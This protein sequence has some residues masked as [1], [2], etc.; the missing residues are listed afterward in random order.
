VKFHETHPGLGAALARHLL[1]DL[2]GEPVDAFLNV[3]EAVTARYPNLP[4]RVQELR[5]SHGL[6]VLLASKYPELRSSVLALLAEDPPV[7]PEALAAVR[8]EHRGLGLKVLWECSRLADERYPGLGLELARARS[9]G[10]RTLPWLVEHKPGYLRDAGRR[11]QANLGE[12]LRR[13]ALDLLAEVETRQKE[14]KPGLGSRLVGL[15]QS[16]Y[17]DLPAQVYQNRWQASHELRSRLRQEF[18]ELPA[19]V[20]Q[21]LQQKHPQLMAR[22]ADSL[23]RHF[24]NLRQE[25]WVALEAELPGLR[26]EVKGF[27]RTRY[28]D[29][30]E[31]LERML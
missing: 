19:L 31:Q 23:Q 7:L 17:P 6:R 2:N 3:A 27:V 1:E 5:R 16:R 13:A 26:E 25:L 18:P 24:P 9:E 15:V 21:T 11:L 28:P 12:T 8:R 22:A 29:L 30:K 4:A 14:R 20:S 10:A